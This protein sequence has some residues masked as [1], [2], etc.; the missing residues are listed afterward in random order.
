MPSQP[1]TRRTRR[2][3]RRN[4]CASKKGMESLR[5]H[6]DEITEQLAGM[7]LIQMLRGAGIRPTAILAAINRVAGVEGAERK[8]AY[9]S[10]ACHGEC[11]CHSGVQIAAVPCPPDCPNA[12][13]RFDGCHRCDCA[14]KGDS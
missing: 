2:S 12:G 4:P 14:P 9:Q 11:L 10:C 8:K 6:L 1:V 7:T 13:T 3:K 5:G